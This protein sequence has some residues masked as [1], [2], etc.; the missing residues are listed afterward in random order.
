MNCTNCGSTND[1]IDFVAGEE[2]LILCATCRY[3]LATGQLVPKATAGRPAK[4]VTKKVS[5][6][7][8]EGVW[9]YFDRQAAGNRSEYLRMLIESDMM[10]SEKWSN[11]AALGYAI[12][13]AIDLGYTEEQTQEL[14]RAIY[15]AFDFKTIE[16]AKQKYN[17]SPY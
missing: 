2:T 11:N 14:V 16:E 3:K 1:V 6:S 8:Q 10:N 4:G 9:D 12:F 7:L 13:G 17:N 15:R 5:I